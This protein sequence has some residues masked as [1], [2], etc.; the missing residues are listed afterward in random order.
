MIFGVPDSQSYLLFKAWNSKG[1][2]LSGMVAI[3]GEKQKYPLKRSSQRAI[4]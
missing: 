1:D 4:L 2:S 3:G